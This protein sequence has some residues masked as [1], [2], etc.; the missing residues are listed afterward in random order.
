LIPPLMSPLADQLIAL[1]PNP[2]SADLYVVLISLLIIHEL[3]NS[4]G[5][6]ARLL[7][8]YLRVV[9][10]PLTVVTILTTIRHLTTGF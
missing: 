6:R 1:Q 2:F 8:R 9:I 10:S 5:R 3:V 7:A 4:A